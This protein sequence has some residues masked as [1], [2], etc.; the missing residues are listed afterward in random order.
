[1]LNRNNGTGGKKITVLF[2]DQAV[3][4]GGS[5]VVIGCLVEA[6]DK[7]RYR[8]IVVGEMDAAILQHNI[9]NHAKIFY[10]SRMFNYALLAKMIKRISRIPGS[11][12]RKLLVYTLSAARGLANMAYGASLVRLILR[13]RVDI[14]HVNNGLG[15][16]APVIAATLLKRKCVVH[17]HGVEKPGR[18]PGLFIQ[19]VSRFIAVSEYLKKCL[20]ENHI[21]EDRMTVMHNPVR[22]KTVQ[23]CTRERVRHRYDILPGQRVFGI[24]GRIVRWKGHIEFLKAAN[25]VLRTMPEAKVLIVGDF[26]DG[27][28]KYQTLIT[29]MVEASEFGDRIIMSGYLN[30][31]EELYSI[32]DVCVHS[33]IEPE[34]FGL[35]ITE[36]MAQGVPVVASNRGAPREIIND[37]V[38][39]F[40]V[41]P[42]DSLAVASVIISLLSNERLRQRIGNKG[43]ERIQKEYQ[44]SNYAHAMEGLY[45]EVLGASY[46]SKVASRHHEL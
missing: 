32:M 46:S 28:I 37:G 19:K 20:V 14:V 2:V 12:I 25:I 15:N 45:M 35:V 36:A 26:S 29:R 13:E 11:L 27:D 7:S 40:L 31:V 17:F 41:D 38:D 4:F 8:P 43:R 30:D 5:I 34:P 22:F 1:M 39:G 24:V 3:A 44:I 23:Q 21:P 10:I 6:I 33:S 42:A 16:L 9:K 18:V